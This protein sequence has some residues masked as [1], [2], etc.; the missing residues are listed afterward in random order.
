MFSRDVV[1]VILTIGLLTFNFDDRHRRNAGC[2]GRFQF[3]C[4]NL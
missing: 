3:D 1:L 4:A 2:G